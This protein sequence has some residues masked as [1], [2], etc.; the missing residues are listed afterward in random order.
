MAEAL[1]PTGPYFVIVGDAAEGPYSAREMAARLETR[2]TTEH[3]LVWSP[4][5]AGWTPAGAVPEMAAILTAPPPPPTPPPPEP[6]LPSKLVGVWL[7][8]RKTEVLEG[9]G[10]IEVI[11]EI[12]IWEDGGIFIKSDASTG[13][14]RK[15]FSYEMNGTLKV[16][17]VA[18]DRL[19]LGISAIRTDW[20][21][22]KA[23]PRKQGTTSVDWQFYSD[24]VVVD[25][26]EVTLRK[27]SA[28]DRP[29]PKPPALDDPLIAKDTP[30][31]ENGVPVGRFRY[32]R[33]EQGSSV[34]STLTLGPGDSYT[35]ILESLD[36]NLHS[37]E[38]IKGTFEV[39]DK[40]ADQVSLYV[41][42][43]HAIEVISVK[44]QSQGGGG[45]SPG[46][47]TTKE[48]EF[49]ETLEIKDANTLVVG[50]DV[51]NRM[52]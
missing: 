13:S 41:K 21:D 52:F 9:V 16:E 10:L 15:T 45:S 20:I 25:E 24:T 8:D 26:R 27:Q 22:G 3:S 28:P 50:G 14:G 5:L 47:E 2:E 32:V 43:L 38:T 11:L 4:S 39:V 51:F 49:S 42:G 19:R 46:S 48:V 37:K 30:G 35:E 23:Q 36:K 12:T 44:G 1:L 18:Q 29:R 34:R 31:F 7:S 33:V 40:N 17:T 6:L